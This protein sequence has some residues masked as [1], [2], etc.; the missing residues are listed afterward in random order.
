MTY[1]YGIDI[2]LLSPFQVVPH[3]SHRQVD[4]KFMTFQKSCIKVLVK[5]E[6]LYFIQHF[7]LV[8]DP[9]NEF[10]KEIVLFI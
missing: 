3:L 10:L 1:Q 9:S 8:Y 2:L 6:F 4:V 5:E 7:F